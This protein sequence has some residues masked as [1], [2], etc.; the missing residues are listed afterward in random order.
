MNPMEDSYEPSHPSLFIVQFNP[1]K[2]SSSL[3]AQKRFDAGEHIVLLEGLSR[4]PKTYTSVQCGSG[5]DD[6]V[7]LNSDLVY[8][9]HSCAPNVAFDLS[10]S[11]PSQWHLRAL[12]TI[13][14][15][16]SLTFFYPSTEW[17]MDQAFDCQCNTENCLGRIQG[18]RYLRKD[19][20]SLRGFINPWILTLA[21]HR[22]ANTTKSECAECGYGVAVDGS[23]GRCG[24]KPT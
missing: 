17:D 10:A 21:N 22:D 3:Q 4:G 12:R 14:P 13:S 1:G 24:C 6:H 7:Q 5:L 15:G 2:F 16:D 9:N 19:V 18:A 8:V 20:L 11:D 23:A